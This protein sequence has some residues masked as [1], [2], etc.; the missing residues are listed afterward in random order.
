MVEDSYRQYIEPGAAG[1]AGPYST[2][3]VHNHYGRRGY[4]LE[5]FPRPSSPG[6]AWLMA[7]PSRLL[8]ARAQVVGFLGRQTELAQLA[9]WRDARDANRSVLL[10]HA[11]GGQGKSRLAA[12]F[13][14]RSRDPRLPN[15]ERWRVSQARLDGGAVRRVSEKD[16]PVGAGAMLIVD[17]ADRWAHD[18]LAA[19][20]AE[21][22]L[23]RAGPTRILLI[24]RT[25]RW[26]AAMRAALAEQRT[27]AGDLLLPPL[28]DE[29]QAM[30][31]A[32]LD[33]FS[34]PDLYDLDTVPATVPLTHPDFGL[35]LTV[36][37]AAL[38][39]VD[40]QH[41]GTRAP[42]TPHELSAY[43]LDREYQ[44]WQ[45]LF[46]A[47]GQGQD[48]TTRPAVMAKAVFT[49]VLTG[50]VSHK[51]GASAV[52]ELDLPGH[53]QE[54]LLDHRFCYP[55]TDRSLVLEPLYPD[56][57]A[58]DFLALLTPGHD[59]SAYDPDPWTLDVPAS[60]LRESTG[61]RTTIV[62]RAMTFLAAAAERWP[63]I[64]EKTLY[65]LLRHD[66]HLAVE[67][68]N[69]ALVALASIP[70]LPF[71][72]LQQ[73]DK[74]LPLDHHIDLDV[75]AA[76]ITDVL[77]PLLLDQAQDPAVR[78]SLH[79]YYSSRLAAAGR[80]HEALEQ[81]LLA[82]PLVEELLAADR[83]THLPIIA[84]Q[85]GN[86][87]IRLAQAGR[88]Q[89]AATTSRRSVDY[90]GELAA[91]DN[92]WLPEAVR[93]MSNHAARLATLSQHEEAARFSL[94]AVHLREELVRQ[95]RA[96]HL[97]GLAVSVLSHARRLAELRRLAEA[98][99][100]SGL[101][102]D[103][104]TELVDAD[105]ATHL[106]ELIIALGIHGERLGEL[107]RRE[108]ALALSRRAFDLAESLVEANHDAYLPLLLA[109]AD[110]HASDLTLLGR[111]HEAIPVSQRNVEL[112]EELVG[113]NR[114]GELHR[115][116]RAFT[117]HAT[118][119]ALT[120]HREPALEHAQRAVAVS[121]E[122]SPLELAG[123]LLGHTAVRILLTTD[124]AQAESDATRALTIYR[125]L[126]SSEPAAF[127]DHVRMAETFLAK[128]RALLNRDQ[129]GE[130]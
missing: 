9:D 90:Y 28:R 5:E 123:A 47:G 62:S 129:R 75:G 33:R 125:K 73:V 21:P 87:A 43:L 105:R 79:G 117:T 127:A 18:E 7:Q 121:E 101:A 67:A 80:H 16:E 100:Y 93:V 122:I 102:V 118:R 83:A 38:V 23:N 84:I 91:T 119:L 126:G 1:A 24:G 60:L 46:D 78:V 88:N 74:E 99:V 72:V 13:A 77:A 111:V 30:F 61:L 110:R 26:F 85:L 63:H 22:A 114:S 11:P 56:R 48:Y 108:E 14:E 86:H 29:R 10:L 130:R 3:T 71:E 37:M 49:A 35:A 64:G 25:V 44:A 41:R 39:A 51:T 66:P 94:R 2:A 57:L 52:R 58:E 4:G 82:A 69:A 128:T 32:A 97:P 20:L 113:I 120:G 40:A 109:A 42:T 98:L 106:P 17:Y 104:L 96:A 76:A 45:R 55:P 6:N 89:E 27:W 103:H 112:A 50:A 116:V 36:Q 68:G 81:S 8:D 92:T 107:G 15:A 19:L 70:D 54:L 95:D 115:V 34:A 59:I 124:L 12:E 53:P 65:P 31:A